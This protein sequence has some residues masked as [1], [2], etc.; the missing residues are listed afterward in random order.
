M[1]SYFEIG[2][3]KIGPGAPGYLIAEVA[4]AHDGSLGTAHAFIDAAAKAGADAIKFQTHLAE[5]ESTR[6]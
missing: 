4:Q 1:T 6:D 2:E 3:R 5:A